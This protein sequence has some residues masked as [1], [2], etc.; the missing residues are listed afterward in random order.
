MLDDLRMVEWIIKSNM[1]KFGQELYFYFKSI[2][3]RSLRLIHA[4]TNARFQ[5]LVLWKLGDMNRAYTETLQYMSHFRSF[6]NHRV[7]VYRYLEL[8]FL[9]LS[10]DSS[11]YTPIH[12]STIAT[13][14]FW[15]GSA[16]A[17]RY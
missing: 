2:K 7:Y 11:R 15:N 4:N 10:Q 13:Y 3:V 1:D 17:G 8:I 14:R 16:C 12:S 6:G 5:I 9:I